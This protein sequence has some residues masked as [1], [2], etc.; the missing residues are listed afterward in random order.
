[1]SGT[2]EQ[3]EFFEVSVSDPILKEDASGKYT[4]YKVHYEVCIESVNE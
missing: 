2:Y 4:A 3:Y 1:M